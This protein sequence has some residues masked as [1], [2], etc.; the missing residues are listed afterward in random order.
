MQRMNKL[1]QPTER[2][3]RT[4]KPSTQ[5]DD[6]AVEGDDRRALQGVELRELGMLREELARGG[7]AGFEDPVDP[8]GID[9]LFGPALLMPAPRSRSRR[10]SAGRAAAL[11]N[12]TAFGRRRCTPRKPP[13]PWRFVP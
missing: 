8:D 3:S 11:R 1:N 12:G 4:G 9:S 5:L 2:S 7:R 10:E 13:K 6:L